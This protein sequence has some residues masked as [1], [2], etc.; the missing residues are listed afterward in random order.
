MCMKHKDQ[1]SCKK[2]QVQEDKVQSDQTDELI[3]RQIN[4]QTER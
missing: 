3:I 4:S 1:R 2:E